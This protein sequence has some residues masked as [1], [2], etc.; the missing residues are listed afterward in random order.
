[1]SGGSSALAVAGL[2]PGLVVSAS[3]PVYTLLEPIPEANA[4][5]AEDSHARIDDPLTRSGAQQRAGW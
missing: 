2:Q 5:C 4:P 3:L 1:M